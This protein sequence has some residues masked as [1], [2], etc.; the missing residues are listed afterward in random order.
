MFPGRDLIISPAAHQDQDA[1]DGKKQRSRKR[2]RQVY[3]P[4]ER[5]KAAQERHSAAK[6]SLKSAFASFQNWL[7]NTG[8]VNLHDAIKHSRDGLYR[9]A[10]SRPDQADLT[11]VQT[12]GCVGHRIAQSIFDT[13]N[14]SSSSSHRNE[15]SGTQRKPNVKVIVSDCD[16]Q[17]TTYFSEQPCDLL[18]LAEMQHIIKP[19]FRVLGTQTNL[20]NCLISNDSENEQEATAHETQILMPGN[21]RFLMADI[22]RF[23]ILLKGK[24][25][26]LQGHLFCVAIFPSVVPHSYILNSCNWRQSFEQLLKPFIQLMLF[27]SS[28]FIGNILFVGPWFAS[29]MILRGDLFDISGVL[30]GVVYTW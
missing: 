7:Q 18:A 6:P 16:A 22:S 3:E 17:T 24:P 20:F 26:F 27:G 8:K 10:P 15:V 21:S 13:N 12:E 11:G 30:K 1:V 14:R 29:C 9:G 23:K 4:N 19:K 5:E 2:K 28:D 25:S